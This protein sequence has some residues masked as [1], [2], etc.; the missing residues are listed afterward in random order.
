[1]K[2]CPRCSKTY[3]TNI[4]RCPDDGNLLVSSKEMSLVGTRID[5]RYRLTG[6]LGRG[7]MG[8]VYRA[9]HEQLGRQVALKIIHRELTENEQLTQRFLVEAKA[10]A[11]LKS[12]HTVTL[13]D[14]GQAEDERLYYTMELLDG[15]PLTEVLRTRGR[16]G[17]DEAAEIVFQ[18]LDSLEEAHEHGILHR[19]I[20]PENIFI[21]SRKGLPHVTVVD[22]GIAKLFGQPSVE[23]IT[24]TGVICGTPAY[25]SPEQALGNPV[26]PPSDLYSLGIVL[27]EILSGSPPF[28]ETTPMKVLMKHIHEPPRPLRVEGSGIEVPEPVERVLEK[29]LEKRPEARFQCASAFRA[30][31]LAVRGSGA[32]DDGGTG[33]WATQVDTDPGLAETVYAQPTPEPGPVHERGDS[34]AAV[35]RVPRSGLSRRG[36]RIISIISLVLVVGFLGVLLADRL[37]PPA[38][39]ESAPSQAE[40]GESTVLGT[41]GDAVVAPKG[42]T[43]DPAVRH[44][45]PRHVVEG[46]VLVIERDRTGDGTD[47]VALVN[48]HMWVLVHR[49]DVDLATP[50]HNL[51]AHPFIN[52]GNVFEDWEGK[53]FLSGPIVADAFVFD[54]ETF[55]QLETTRCTIEVIE[56]GPDRASYKVTNLDVGGTAQIERCFIVELVAGE[57]AATIRY[58]WTNTGSTVAKFKFPVSYKHRGT[59][60]A[61]IRTRSKKDIAGWI[62]GTGKIPLTELEWWEIYPVDPLEP[63]FLLYEPVRERGVLF[64]MRSRELAPAYAVAHYRSTS[65]AIKPIIDMLAQELVLEP[66]DSVT[67]TAALAFFKGGVEEGLA[68]YRAD[69][70]GDQVPDVFDNCPDVRNPDQTDGNDDGEGDACCTPD[71]D[72]KRCGDDGCGGSCGTCPPGQTCHKD[73]RI[74]E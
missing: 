33:V 1:M 35:P 24:Q 74:C 13:F 62:G 72:G 41:R 69:K 5:G 54:G 46:R 68:I 65:R 26:G 48:E 66:G 53:L 55:M 34:V 3:T 17:L 63:L 4:S 22:F 10:I 71:C 16:L 11:S 60:I 36:V 8:V 25:M 27:Y 29:V 42:D 14:F 49:D 52:G 23:S 15:G 20:K 18:V 45:I 70:D 64:S 12:A 19:D 30:A 31:L 21:E 67:G 38:E 40:N 57:Q 59:F 58:R 32:R 39:D 37:Q 47:D 2:T 73:F 51:Y 7:G 44:E 28:Q 56:R 43:A 9:E 61:G 6:L 50:L